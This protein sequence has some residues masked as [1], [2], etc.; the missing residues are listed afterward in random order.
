MHGVK[1]KVKKIIAVCSNTM[2]QQLPG[3]NDNIDENHLTRKTVVGIGGLE[4]EI[5]T[6]NPTD[7]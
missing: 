4:T 1:M 6:R 2:L 5:Q 3:R 7:N